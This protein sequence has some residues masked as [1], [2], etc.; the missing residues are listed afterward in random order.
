MISTL[1]EKFKQLGILNVYFIALFFYAVPFLSLGLFI[2]D[3][4]FFQKTAMFFWLIFL[5][6]L[7]PCGLIGFLLAIVGFVKSYKNENKLN[8]IIGIIGMVGGIL[9]II[10]GIL[11]IMLIFVVVGAV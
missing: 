4:L 7:I 11:G 3:Q 9:C 2:V 1:M 5:V 6:G 8:K 10:G